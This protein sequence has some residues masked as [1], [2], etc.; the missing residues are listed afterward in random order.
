M[1]DN[2]ITVAKTF[3][4]HL[5]Y[6]NFKYMYGPITREGMVEVDRIM[7]NDLKIGVEL[8]MEHA[9]LNLAKITLSY[10]SKESFDWIVVVAGSGNNGGGGMVAARRSSL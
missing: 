7:E 9:G 1:Y 3:I 8:M 4:K 5:I 2:L 6:Y 10:F